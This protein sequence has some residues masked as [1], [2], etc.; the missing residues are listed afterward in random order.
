[1]DLKP[2]LQYLA[3]GIGMLSLILTVGFL[4]TMAFTD[5]ILRR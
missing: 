1:V 4:A 2:L 3:F 5:D